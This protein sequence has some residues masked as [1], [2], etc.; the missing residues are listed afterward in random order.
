MGKIKTLFVASILIGGNLVAQTSQL[1]DFVKGNTTQNFITYKSNNPLT[2]NSLVKQ[3]KADLGLSFKDV[4]E[5]VSKEIDKI[6]L[7]NYKYQQHY[8]DVEVYGAQYLAHEQNQQLVSS[9]GKLVFG[10]TGNNVAEL[11]VN[12]AIQKAITHVNAQKYMWESNGAEQLLKQIKNDVSATYYPTAKLVYYDRY[13]TQVGNNYRLAYVVEVYAESPVS[14]QDVFIDAETG[15]IIHSYNKIHTAEVTG[16]ATTKYSGIQSI[17][18]DSTAATSFRLREYNRGG[19]IET[20]NMLEG[21]DYAA[22]VDF[23]DADNNWNNVNGQQDE[24]AGDA[25]WAAEMTY[26]YFLSEHGRDSY[27]NMGAKL[28]SYVHYDASY[29]N[30]FWDGVRMSYGDGDASSL[31]ALTSLDIGGHE[32]AHGVTQFS[33]DLV[34]QDESGALNE[35]FSDIF[36]T[37]IE[38]F[39]DPAN[40]DWLIGEDIDLVGNGLRSMIDPNSDGDPDTYF[41]TNWA[42][43]GGADNGGVH[44]NSG[45]Q[46]HWFY[47]LSDG[48]IGTNDNG[49]A[50]NVTGLGIDIA[51]AIA[52]R[53]LTV[54]LTQSSEYIDARNG[55]IQAARDLYGNCS[56]E[57]VQTSK[58]WAAVGV[59]FAIEDNDLTLLTIESPGTVCGLTNSETVAIKI[60][61]NGCLVDLLAGATIPVVF[62]VDGGIINN[63]S[64][65]LTSNFNASDTLSYTFTATA[66]LSTVGI[67]SVSAW[68]EYPLDIQPLN[69]SVVSMQVEHI[70]QQNIDVAMVEILSPVS[71]CQ[72][73]SNETVEVAVQFLGC[74]SLA[75]G[76]NIDVNY[77]L[78]GGTVVNETITLVNVLYA[79]EVLNYTFTAPADLSAKGTYSLDV[80]TAFSIDTIN[81]NNTIAGHSVKNPFGLVVDV[82]VTFENNTVVLDSMLMLDNIE[83]DIAVSNI[84]AASGNYALRMTGGDPLNSGIT[85][86]LDSTNFWSKNMEF[87]TSATFCVDATTWPTANLNFDLRQTLSKTYAFQFGQPLPQAS[88]LRV[89]VNGNQVGGTYNPVTETGDPFANKSI[90]L[91]AYAGTQ[92]ELVFE[93]R[94][95]FSQAAD[96]TGGFPFNSEGD[97][98]YIDNI[99]FSQTVGIE[100]QNQLEEVNVYPNPTNGKFVLSFVANELQSSTIEIY[101]V[102]GKIVISQKNTINIGF[103]EVVI[104]L[105]NQPNNVYIL[106]LTS[107]SENH[108]S[109]IIKR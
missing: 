82:P 22:A 102:L 108:V 11:S 101:D 3:Y 19:G 65:I 6:G 37:A 42:P 96:P 85:P 86:D 43:L 27:D 16:S 71:G 12:S 64:I 47:L 91:D 14:K 29:A 48:G 88:S 57:V 109:R 76:I 53:N 51:A 56:N 31:T 39:A 75:S 41:G 78:N 4:L 33:A 79:G 81:G 36:G 49:D 66:D 99:V 98:A 15:E 69:D 95:G 80:S 100:E 9:N 38:F 34:Y 28:L 62:Q 5:E 25:H 67:H 83:S 60:R 32:I 89:V 72:L 106:K 92:F 107:E 21:T 105:S 54:Y 103:N 45:V 50:Y 74:D 1:S 84:S 20:Y 23:T 73:S 24:V 35:S 46:N 94:M 44:S 70:L 104:D 58:A 17:Q 10:I 93:A 90:N 13:F 55:A 8:N 52:Y 18:T 61:N 2:A 68:V 63:E 7:T 87:A 40:G 97:N 30:A 26:D 77:Q 59:G